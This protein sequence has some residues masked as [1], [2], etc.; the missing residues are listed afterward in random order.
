MS[1]NVKKIIVSCGTAIATS[2]YVA[3]KIE[4]ILK[5][6]GIKGEIVQ[7]KAAELNYYINMLGK[8]DLIVSTT[9]VNVKDIP[10]VNG[11]PFLS[12]VGMDEAKQ[13]IINILKKNT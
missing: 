3:S 12:G 9:P 1:D 4:E 2:S 5:E 10:V 11:V 8:V 7:C 6:N 13:Q